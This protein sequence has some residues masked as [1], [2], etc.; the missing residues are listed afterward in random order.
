M[1]KA[2][3]LS[4]ETIDSRVLNLAREDVV[5]HSVEDLI[6]DVPHRIMLGINLVEFAGESDAVVQAQVSELCASLD[7]QLEAQAAGRVGV[8]GYQICD[9]LD[10]I[11][12]IYAMRK[13]AVG[14]LGATKGKKKTVAF[15]EDTCVSPENLADFI[16]EFRALLDAHH[17]DY[18][19][20]W[21]VDAGVLHVRPALD[22]CDPNQEVLMRQISDQVVA[23]V[24]KVWRFDVRESMEKVIALSMVLSFSEKPCSMRLEK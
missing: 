15:A 8:I 2:N 21:Y 11:N 20:C 14:L 4:V 10:S 23:L 16:A 5:W 24:S 12:R 19:M 9:D 17:L 18:G 3:A 13:K 7:R 6:R 22:L 1:V